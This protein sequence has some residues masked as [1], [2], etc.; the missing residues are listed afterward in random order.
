MKCGLWQQIASV[1]WMHFRRYL[2]HHSSHI[3]SVQWQLYKFVIEQNGWQSRYK[4]DPNLI[5]TGRDLHGDLDEINDVKW[6]DSHKF[7][8]TEAV[9][10]VPEAVGNLWHYAHVEM[11]AKDDND[12]GAKPETA[13]AM[14][15]KEMPLK[16]LKA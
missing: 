7:A 16:I 12:D 1:K 8:R 4:P 14:R 11:R 13:G 3:A 5:Y 10:L 9:I 2:Y 15:L 6:P